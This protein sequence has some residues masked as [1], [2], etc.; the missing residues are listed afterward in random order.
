M[1]HTDRVRHFGSRSSSAA[2]MPVSLPMAGTPRGTAN[3]YVRVEP[4]LPET[5][6]SDRP[7]GSPAPTFDG[8]APGSS[9]LLEPSSPT[10][11]VAHLPSGPPMLPSG[12]AALTDGLAARPSSPGSPR[13][14]SRR[15][16]S[17][18]MGHLPASP[19][20]LTREM[21]PYGHLPQRRA[22]PMLTEPEMA[23]FTPEAAHL[24]MVFK[25]PMSPMMTLASELQ[26]AGFATTVV[27]SGKAAQSAMLTSKKAG[28]P[29]TA[30]VCDYSSGSADL[31]RTPAITMPIIITSALP[32][33][34]WE[35]VCRQLGAFDCLQLPMPV[36]RAL[37]TIRL[38][39]ASRPLLSW[40]SARL[41]KPQ[42]GVGLASTAPVRRLI[43]TAS[44]SRGMRAGSKPVNRGAVAAVHSPLAVSADRHGS[45]TARPRTSPHVGSRR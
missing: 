38:A 43:R 39:V 18:S 2:P 9:S 30:V 13:T 44:A 25:D 22:R 35:G 12:M 7:K 3:G 28:V 26:A 1:N 15:G 17:H 45:P 40:A 14:D 21:A 8:D 34:R 31:L 19:S 36:E 23:A 10:V 42:P 20:K 4:M 33:P 5:P 29:F 41:P 24:L 27:S 6:T 37:P 11:A 32:M 16:L